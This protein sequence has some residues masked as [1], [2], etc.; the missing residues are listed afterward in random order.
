MLFE[1]QSWRKMTGM[2]SLC[3]IELLK[4]WSLF[5][6]GLNRFCSCMSCLP[7]VGFFCLQIILWCMY[8]RHVH[9]CLYFCMYCRHVHIC[10]YFC[11]YCIHI[12]VVCISVCIVYMYMYVCISVCIVYMYMYVCISVCIYNVFVYSCCTWCLSSIN[13]ILR[14]KILKTNYICMKPKRSDSVPKAGQHLQFCILKSRTA[15]VV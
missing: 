15:S 4:N 3:H 7:P 6:K 12:H 8:C 13:T 14:K 9:V 10:L 1:K 11:M 5:L 2:L